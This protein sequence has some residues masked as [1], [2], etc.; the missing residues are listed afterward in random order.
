MFLRRCRPAVTGVKG[1]LVLDVLRPPTAST[2]SPTR[3]RDGGCSR[4]G[5][6]GP[7]C[8]AAQRGEDAELRL[9]VTELG[10]V[11]LGG[12]SPLRAGGCRSHRGAPAGSLDRADALLRNHPRAA[13]GDRIL[14]WSSPVPYLLTVWQRH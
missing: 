2:P 9:G 11:Y 6:T 8:R 12:I 13:H 14:I 5:R 1:R 4:P 3:L 7:S 10:S